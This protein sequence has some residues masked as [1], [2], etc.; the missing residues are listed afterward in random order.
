ME[1]VA[2][3]QVQLHQ[4]NAALE[5]QKQLVARMHADLGKLVESN[6]RGDLEYRKLQAIIAKSKEMQH[7]S[8]ILEE[9]D[10]YV[11]QSRMLQELLRENAKELEKYK[12]LVAASHA[13]G[14][15]PAASTGAEASVVDL[16]PLREEVAAQEQV[17]AAVKA[18]C[19]D[20][21][22]GTAA[23]AA[24][25]DTPDPSP[26][27]LELR[28]AQANLTAAK[29]AL[30]VKEEEVESSTSAA[31]RASRMREKVEREARDKDAA[32]VQALREK[33]GHVSHLTAKVEA[34]VANHA[35]DLQ[36]MY[37]K[38][39]EKETEVTAMQKKLE[40]ASRTVAASESVARLT[41]ASRVA[42][43]AIEA[44]EAE[45]KELEDKVRARDKRIESL[46]QAKGNAEVQLREVTTSLDET[47]V[48]LTSLEA[49][50][51]TL[52]ART[53]QLESSLTA[54]LE[55][56]QELRPM[57][58]GF[59][60]LQ[61]NAERLQSDLTAAQ[62]SMRAYETTV[63]QLKVELADAET[64]TEDQKAEHVIATR[65]L[66]Q[67]NKELK[68][69][70]GKERAK[71]AKPVPQSPV[72][73][74]SP[75]L[76]PSTPTAASVPAFS[77]AT[78]P[79]SVAVTPPFTS[80]LPPRPPYDASGGSGAAASAGAG[81]G[82]GSGVG[83]G[84]PSRRA[85]QLGD[86]G[87]SDETMQLLAKRIQSLLAE[88]EGVRERIRFLEGIVQSLT[89]D[90]DN[91]RAMTKQLTSSKSVVEGTSSTAQSVVDKATR[92]ENPIRVLQ[93][94]LLKALTENERLK[95][96]MRVLGAEMDKVLPSPSLE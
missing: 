27:L 17:L 77:A 38:L 93:S 8:A 28:E 88:N 24:D 60:A 74:P 26:L 47:V 65:M 73:A 61:A 12:K 80:S 22:E 68:A 11:Q 4:A 7:I 18:K 44:L 58:S 57:R 89:R 53:S 76:K 46:T 31:I 83:A 64:R 92:S 35:K 81:A 78:T 82:A 45:N 36:G 90:N 2:K 96:D 19:A 1:E 23:L 32:M 15:S 52:R 9:K 94:L 63:T 42:S 51:R 95:N 29:E 70:L 37:L 91:Y 16:Q 49:S 75:L 86:T 41:E 14:D 21:D 87:S 55:E 3:L 33:E 62:D 34:L 67:M 79:S 56:L 50:D 85:S 66:K 20:C 10:T 69:Q 5:E 25:S 30:R 71:E 43:A 39:K 59:E 54:A 6:R 72:P 84:A 48:S 13:E 40:D